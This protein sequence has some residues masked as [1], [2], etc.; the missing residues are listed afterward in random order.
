MPAFRLFGLSACRLVGKLAGCAV[1]WVGGGSR[2]GAGALPCQQ[3]A[4]CSCG[5]GCL[6]DPAQVRQRPAEEVRV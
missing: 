4:G 3:G 2:H 6:A 1:R 5:D